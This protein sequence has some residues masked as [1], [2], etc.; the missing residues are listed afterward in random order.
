VYIVASNECGP[1]SIELDPSL[2]IVFNSGLFARLSALFF[3]EG[4]VQYFSKIPSASHF[5]RE[6][7]RDAART[8]ESAIVW[9]SFADNLDDWAWYEVGKGLLSVT[10]VGRQSSAMGVEGCREGVRSGTTLR[11]LYLAGFV[12]GG[13]PGVD[14]FGVETDFGV[15]IGEDARLFAA[16]SRRSRAGRTRFDGAAEGS[17]PSCAAAS[18]LAIS[19]V[20]VAPESQVS[21]VCL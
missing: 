18:S 5:K 11:L 19:V 16:D 2:C 3:F 4:F 1:I 21:T 12:F 14:L 15:E 8:A 13:L 7:C 20:C 10:L 6:R 9:Y 17:S